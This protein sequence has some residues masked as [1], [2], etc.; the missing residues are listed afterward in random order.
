MAKFKQDPKRNL[1]LSIDP[2][3]HSMG[4]CI[5]DAD[6]RDYI[7]SATFVCHEGAWPERMH[8]IAAQSEKFLAKYWERVGYIAAEL[9]PPLGDKGIQSSCGA[10]LSVYPMHAQVNRNTFISPSSWKK[11]ARLAGCSMKD[12]KGIEAALSFFTEH[13]FESDDEAD[14]ALIGMCWMEKQWG[15]L[16]PI[17]RKPV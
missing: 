5:F 11:M 3:S 12:P 9:I 15:A 2:G 14:A 4:I 13:S 16:R 6:T 7:D 1:L 10:V 17:T 8:S